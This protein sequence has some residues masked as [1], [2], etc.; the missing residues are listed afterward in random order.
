MMTLKKNT[1]FGMFSSM[2]INLQYGNWWTE[3]VEPSR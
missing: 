2:P 3:G 1:S